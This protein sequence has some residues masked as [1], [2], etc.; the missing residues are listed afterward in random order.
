MGDTVPITLPPGA[1]E[2]LGEVLRALTLAAGDPRITGHVMHVAGTL[3]ALAG[4]GENATDAD[5][6]MLAA[7]LREA[8]A[9]T[10]PVAGDSS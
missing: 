5:A 7:M 3:R 2:L 8:L 1:R 4:L 10:A 9:V 6:A